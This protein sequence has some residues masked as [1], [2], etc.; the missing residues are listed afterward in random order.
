MPF[1]ALNPLDFHWG[2]NYSRKTETGKEVYFRAFLS[3]NDLKWVISCGGNYMPLWEIIGYL[4]KV[5]RKIGPYNSPMCGGWDEN[6][7][8]FMGKKC[9]GLRDLRKEVFGVDK[10]EGVF[11]LLRI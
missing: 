8:L 3:G 1:L 2:C 6:C 10:G 11:L 4:G 7:L 9:E 5:R